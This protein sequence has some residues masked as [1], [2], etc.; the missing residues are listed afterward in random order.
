[1]FFSNN[2]LCI[3]DKDNTNKKQN[4]GLEI[5]VTQLLKKWNLEIYENK[6]KQEEYDLDGFL[7]ITKNELR[8][9]IKMKGGHIRKFIKNRDEYLKNNKP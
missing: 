6:F 1:M 7:E 5:V 4:K 8:E 3:L 2:F 9:F